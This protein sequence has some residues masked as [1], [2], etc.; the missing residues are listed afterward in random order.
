MKVSIQKELKAIINPS[1]YNLFLLHF[2]TKTNLFAIRPGKFQQFSFFKI[3][4][5][6]PVLRIKNLKLPLVLKGETLLILGIINYYGRI[7]PS[8]EFSGNTI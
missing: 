8:S 4:V 6:I 7:Y 2:I 1:Y 3:R 5:L